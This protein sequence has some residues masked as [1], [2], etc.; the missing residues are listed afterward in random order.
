MH[1]LNRPTGIEIVVGHQS[2]F[3]L[4]AA[5]TNVFFIVRE[6]WSNKVYPKPCFI[7]DYR[8]L[9]VTWDASPTTSRRLVLIGPIV[10][11]VAGRAAHGDGHGG[12][13][14]DSLQNFVSLC[15]SLTYVYI[16]I[17]RSIT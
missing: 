6:L 16:K 13:A 15:L 4:D 12:T 7:G 9:Y 14:V 11:S 5:G 1:R 10:A 3:A 8:G 17:I 2:Q